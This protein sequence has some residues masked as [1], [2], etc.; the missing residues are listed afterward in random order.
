MKCTLLDEG[1]VNLRCAYQLTVFIPSFLFFITL[2]KLFLHRKDES[3]S[4]T[5][6]SLTVLVVRRPTFFST[7]D[8]LYQRMAYCNTHI[9]FMYCITLVTLWSPVTREAINVRITDVFCS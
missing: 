5:C 9:C 2:S 3:C 1:L 6:F 7:Y 4:E 8:N